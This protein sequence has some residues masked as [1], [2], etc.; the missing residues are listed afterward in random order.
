MS[1]I[2]RL[3]LNEFTLWGGDLVSV[4]HIR[5]RPYYRGF[6]KRLVI[7]EKFVGTLETAHNRQ[8]CILERCLY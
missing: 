6:F 2:K 7:N 8:L 4:F 1:V 3:I 5:E